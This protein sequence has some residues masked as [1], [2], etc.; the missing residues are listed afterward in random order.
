MK[1]VWGLESGS[2][3]L[4]FFCCNAGGEHYSREVQRSTGLS[5]G[6]VNQACRTLW[7]D[8]FLERRK[9]GREYFYSLNY[10]HAPAKAYKVFVTLLGLEPDIKRLS[11]LSKR[12]W[13][14]GSS[15][16]GTDGPHSDIDLLVESDDPK[17]AKTSSELMKKNTRE[18]IKVKTTEEIFTLK[19][20]D[21]AFYENAVLRG[22]LI[23]E[24]TEDENVRR[25]R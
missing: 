9:K 16:K 22:I 18:S 11:P 15:A 13:L 19:K 3:V 6:A 14:Y 8:G 21:P 10:G 20:K 12:I 7:K 23:H 24:A 5:A 4:G 17:A 1:H 25:V 2:K